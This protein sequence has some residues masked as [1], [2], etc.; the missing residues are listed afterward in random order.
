MSELIVDGVKVSYH[1]A[2]SGPVCLAHSGGPGIHFEYLRMPELEHHLTMVYIEPVGTGNSDLLPDGDYSMEYYAHYANEVARQLGEEK[3][4]FLGHS[5]GGFVALQ[6]ALDHPE[7]LAGI[8]VYDSMAFNGPELGEE[9]GRRVDEYA[10]EHPGDPVADQVV[11]AWRED[12]DLPADK[13][14]H[15][16][17]LRRLLPVYFKDFRGIQDRIADWMATLDLTLDPNRQPSLWDVR[18]RLG[19]ITVPTLVLVGAAD[20]ICGE[21]FARQLHDGIPGSQLV[22]FG[23]SGHFAHLEEPQAFF[24][25]V[26]GFVSAH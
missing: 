10:A 11:Q 19:E 14:A 3:V 4:F 23:E 12:A 15:L 5:H 20:F 8:I 16:D 17:S 26:L 24:A 2:G 9:A 22:V 13:A 7:S 21:K 18:D 6:F 25:A 1:V